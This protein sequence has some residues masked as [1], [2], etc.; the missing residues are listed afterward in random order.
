[1]DF[2]RFAIQ[3]FSPSLIR[4][5]CRDTFYC[6]ADCKAPSQTAVR[7]DK[8]QT[9]RKYKGID[10]NIIISIIISD[11]IIISSSRIKILQIKIIILAAIVMRK[12][13]DSSEKR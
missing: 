2:K 6:G 3:N 11:I 9:N 1:M 7:R 13:P 8:N 10:I 4:D 12:H 5:L